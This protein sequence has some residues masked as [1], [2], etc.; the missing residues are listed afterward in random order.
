M[1]NRL[2][3]IV[4][5]LLII[6][7]VIFVL[8]ELFAAF[9][10][11][12]YLALWN[13]GS[14]NFK[15]YQFFSYMFAHGDFWHLFHNMLLLFFLAPMLESFWGSK[16]FLA[17]FMIA[18]LGGSFVYSGV[19]YVENYGINQAVNTYLSNP[20]P[21]NFNYL[22]VDKFDGKVNPKV[23]DLV[24]QYDQ[25]PNDA[26][27]ID[28]S[29]KEAM[30]LSNASTEFGSMLGASGAVFGI[31]IAVGLIFANHDFNLLFIPVPIKA[32]YIVFGYIAYDVLKNIQ[33]A[34][35][36]NVAHWAHYGGAIFGFLVVK[37][38]QYQERN[39]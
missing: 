32:K 23:Y 4:K 6:N 38:W 27:Y 30:T 19:N 33:S 14:S 28:Q 35:G 36:D 2:T 15:P 34:P 10:I 18:G 13:I 12:S 26:Y 25:N 11:T 3:P 16:K 37:Y 22:I 31:L 9:N 39:S 20:S 21:E 5:N 1:L 7:V 29:K 24:D 17:F 8:Q